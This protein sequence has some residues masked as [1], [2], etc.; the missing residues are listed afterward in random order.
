[1]LSSPLSKM[2]SLLESLFDGLSGE[3]KKNNVMHEQLEQE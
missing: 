3:K 1:M 2:M